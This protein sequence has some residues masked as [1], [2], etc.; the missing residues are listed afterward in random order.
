M[1]IP[2]NSVWSAAGWDRLLSQGR[3]TKNCT[4]VLSIVTLIIFFLLLLLYDFFFKRDILN[5]RRDLINRSRANA[6]LHMTSEVTSQWG[7]VRMGSVRHLLVMFMIAHSLY[8]V[9]TSEDLFEFLLMRQ[10]RTWK[11]KWRPPEPQFVF[12]FSFSPLCTYC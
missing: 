9:Q 5:S 1:A 12:F 4:W 10:K 3:L 2:S 7:R 6:G 8:G 11:L